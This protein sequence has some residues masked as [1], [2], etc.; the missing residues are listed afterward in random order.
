MEWEAV[1]RERSLARWRRGS[2]VEAVRRE[3]ISRRS[4]ASVSRAA[5]VAEV[6]GRVARSRGKA[7]ISFGRCFGGVLVGFR[8]VGAGMGGGFVLSGSV[9]C[10]PEKGDRD[11]KGEA[12][13][14]A[15]IVVVRYGGG[16]GVGGTVGRSGS[17]GGKGGG[18]WTKAVVEGDGEQRRVFKSAFEMKAD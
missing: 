10:A 8:F 2:G 14:T 4:C 18:C 15:K 16:W 11:G 9:F 13:Q 17:G 5:V 12:T 3:V 7:G 6:G 1:T